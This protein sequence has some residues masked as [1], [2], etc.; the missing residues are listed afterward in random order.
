MGGGMGGIGISLGEGILGI[1]PGG[2]GRC[3]RAGDE[4]PILS[5]GGNGRL[6]GDISGSGTAGLGAGTGDLGPGVVPLALD[7]PGSCRKT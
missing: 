4:G 3:T 5:G 6:G 2:R 1:R 7:E